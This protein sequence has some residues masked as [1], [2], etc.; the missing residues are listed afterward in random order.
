VDFNDFSPKQCSAGRNYINLLPD[1]QV[2]TCAAGFSY[3]YSPLYTDLVKNRSLEHFRMPNLFDPD[4]RLNPTDLVCKLPCKD[5]CD[6]DSVLITIREQEE[7][8]QAT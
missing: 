2:F 8:L 4:F 6:R 1:G 3:T 5:A 7:I